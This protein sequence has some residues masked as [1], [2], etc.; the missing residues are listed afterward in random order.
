[1]D[2]RQSYDLIFGCDVISQQQTW[3]NV[4]RNTI[5]LTHRN[6]TVTLVEAEFKTGE[7]SP[8]DGLV[9]VSVSTGEQQAHHSVS[10]TTL[11]D[12]FGPLKTA[13]FVATTTGLATLDHA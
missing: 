2:L 6:Q 9:S 4:D 7:T 3:L 1:M 8:V 12:E 13:M 11:E 5:Q 10:F